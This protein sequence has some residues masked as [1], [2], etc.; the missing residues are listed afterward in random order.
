[1]KGKSIIQ[2][3]NPSTEKVEEQFEDKN[4]IT[5]AIPNAFKMSNLYKT[6][7]H[8]DTTISEY[9]R[10]L[11]PLPTGGFGGITLWGET[12]PEN[13]DFIFPIGIKEV[14]RAGG[15]YSGSNLFRG[16]L[17]TNESIA[18]TNGWRN[19]WD[20]GTDKCNGATI[21][22]LSLTHRS[23]G[24][25]GWINTTTESLA[26]FPSSSSVFNST[27]SGKP[28]FIKLLE[29]HKA[30]YVVSETTTTWGLYVVQIPNIINGYKVTD[31][32]INF[33]STGKIATATFPVARSLRSIG[34]P[35]IIGNIAHFICVTSSSSISHVQL[36]LT[37]Y[38][39]SETIINIQTTILN[40]YSIIGRTI[41]YKDHYYL[42]SETGDLFKHDLSGKRVGNSFLSGVISWILTLWN[43][44]LCADYSQ[45]S[46]STGT[47]YLFDGQS[48]REFRTTNISNNAAIVESNNDLIKYP[49]SL[50][51]RNY[52]DDYGR[53]SLVGSNYYLGSINN[54][55]TPITKTSDFNMKII[56]ELTNG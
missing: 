19:V 6:Q 43:G 52:G 41:F 3:I 14:G 30:L 9:I 8:Q 17:N 15:A 23:V 56:Y 12:L 32:G 1:M 16:N 48:F 26:I 7:Y 49:I 20:F 10:Q 39:V 28:V 45:S 53:L 55:A 38:T 11:T 54:L 34:F 13:P 18:I 33:S 37:D 2:M 4:L 51:Y 44:F 42:I 36:N 25:N 40:T 29:P 31:M 35:N 47:K 5:N 24:N 50:A 22:S 46:S 21:K 27:I